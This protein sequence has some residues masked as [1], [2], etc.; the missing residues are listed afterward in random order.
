MYVTQPPATCVTISGTFRK[1]ADKPT[2]RQRVPPHEVEHC[3]VEEIT[4]DSG[5]TVG[6]IL[7]K[8]Q[9]LESQ[10]GATFLWDPD[11]LVPG[12]VFLTEHDISE[13]EAMDGGSDEAAERS[14]SDVSIESDLESPLDFDG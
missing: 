3:T 6:H 1:P 4:H 8:I 2:R 11:I 12:P 13:L 5:V 9:E 7:D 10:L 14:G